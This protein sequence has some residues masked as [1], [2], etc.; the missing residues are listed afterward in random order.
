MSGHISALS[1]TVKS[2]CFATQS[3]NLT[4]GRL[5]RP[6][7]YMGDGE[8]AIKLYEVSPKYI[9]Y[10]VPYAPHLFHNKKP[11]QQNE[12]KYI[13]VILMVDDMK[14]FAPLSSYKPKHEKMKDGL[15]FVKI[16]NYAVVN[17][18]NMFPV[19]DGEYTYVDIAEVKN[20]QYRKLLMTEYRILRKLQDKIKKNAAVLYKHKKEKGTSTA[21]AKR[22]ND[23]QLLEEKCHQYCK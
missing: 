19:P 8:L 11:G 18:N 7:L 17:I 12:R 3:A 10:L 16:E 21:L 6:I 22:C 14:Y 20:P 5:I 2:E 4:V 15:D 1:E 13:G 9:D 23:F